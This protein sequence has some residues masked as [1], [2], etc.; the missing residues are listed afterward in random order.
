[1]H[2]VHA[3]GYRFQ[4]HK[5]ISVFYSVCVFFRETLTHYLFSVKNI[6]CCSIPALRSR[7]VPILWTPLL[8]SHGQSGACWEDRCSGGVKRHFE[9]HGWL[10]EELWATIEIL[11]AGGLSKPEENTEERRGFKT[12]YHTICHSSSF[13]GWLWWNAGGFL[14]N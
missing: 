10:R 5:A 1:M 2:D 4:F 3:C 9:P 12:T 6:Q 11:T 14:V 13:S 7:C 8:L